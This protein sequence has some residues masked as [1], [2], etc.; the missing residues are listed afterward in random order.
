[1]SY[2]EPYSDPTINPWLG[3]NIRSKDDALIPYL[4]NLTA[5][6]DARRG[7]LIPDYLDHKFPTFEQH[8]ESD[9]LRT[10]GL[11]SEGLPHSEQPPPL[12]GDATDAPALPEQSWLG[13]NQHHIAMAAFISAMLAAAGPVLGRLGNRSAKRVVSRYIRPF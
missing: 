8:R 5:Q 1:M 3:R 6:I 2:E 12:S 13:R 4:R 9:A 10:L 11:S 7:R